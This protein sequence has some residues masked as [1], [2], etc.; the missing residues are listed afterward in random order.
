MSRSLE[1]LREDALAI[2]HA[3]VNAVQSDRLV[4]DF[5]QVAEGLLLCG[6]FELPLDQIGKIAVVG[7]GKA[8]AGM[9]KGLEQSLGADLCKRKLTGLVN[10]PAD[11]AKKLGV[12]KL[13]PGRPAKLN[14]PT[15]EGV[16]GARQMLELVSSLQKNDLC[17][18]LLS[19]GGSALLPLP[20]S[21]ITLEDKLSVTRFLALR[22]ANIAQ[23]NTVRKHL[24]AIKGGRLASAC[25]AGFLI[26]LVISDVMGDPLDVIA[27]GPTYPDSTTTMH[28]REILT[29]FG[30]GKEPWFARVEALL[31][32]SHPPPRPTAEIQHFIIGN[33]AVAVDAAG[34]EAESRGYS[35]A[36]TSSRKLEGDAEELG[37][38]LAQLAKQMRDN[39]GPDCLISGGEP[40]VAWSGEN[41]RGLGGRNQQLTLAAVDEVRGDA[42]GI[43][44][45]SGGTDGEDGPTSA[46]GAWLNEL[47][48]ANAQKLGLNPATFLAKQDAYHFF[49]RVGGLIETGAT[50]TNVGDLRVIVV[51]RIEDK[52]HESNR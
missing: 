14:E 48:Y 47:T 20:A 25:R 28:A 22:G 4:Q 42:H 16:A 5:V 29:Q 3:G 19:G 39:K 27:S 37:R 45:L 52:H 31:K 15:A 21:G 17:I 8:G 43:C 9:A 34:I 38:N 23:L 18:C 26:T 40:V 41:E 1:K 44:M 35:H 7:A 11:C 13:I 30:A 6:D 51:D 12:I 46:A 49:Q 32:S 2:W 24:S 50:H 10:V 36:M 33:N